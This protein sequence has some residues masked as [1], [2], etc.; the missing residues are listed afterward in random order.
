VS[1]L[2]NLYSDI[3]CFSEFTELEDT[4]RH[5]DVRMNIVDTGE[6][7]EDIF[8]ECGHLTTAT[9]SCSLSACNE[10]TGSE[11]HKED[12]YPVLKV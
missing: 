7:M 1:V 5:K 8:A 6:E 2:D 9:V 12:S 3:L 10:I 11:L 4:T